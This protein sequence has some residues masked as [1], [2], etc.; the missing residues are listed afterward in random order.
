MISFFFVL[1]PSSKEKFCNAFS[2]VKNET[3]WIAK[4]LITPGREKLNYCLELH[5]KLS[6]LQ[7]P[8]YNLSK[9]NPTLWN[10]SRATATLSACGT[11]IPSEHT[12]H[13]FLAL[14]QNLLFYFIG[15]FAFTSEKTHLFSVKLTNLLEFRFFYAYQMLI[16]IIKQRSKLLSFLISHMNYNHFMPTVHN[17]PDWDLSSLHTHNN[18]M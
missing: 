6:I 17:S 1:W 14:K 18:S 16:R 5:S 13:F 3:L 8:F 2:A 15:N 9:C 7:S 10:N 11:G 4:H 12:S